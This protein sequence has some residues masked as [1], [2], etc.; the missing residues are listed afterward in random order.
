MKKIVLLLIFP[1]YLSSRWKI[2]HVCD[3][4]KLLLMDTFSGY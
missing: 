4:R 1:A 3:K 2:V